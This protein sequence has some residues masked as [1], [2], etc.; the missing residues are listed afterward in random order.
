[1][2]ALGVIPNTDFMMFAVSSSQ[3]GLELFVKSSNSSTPTLL[4]DIDGTCEDSLVQSVLDITEVFFAH[5]S[6]YF[7]V[8]D[9]Q[10]WVT[11]GTNEST[12][13]VTTTGTWN[14]F[15][16]YIHPYHHLIYAQVRLLSND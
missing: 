1:M 8:R 4:R 6:M 9:N 13:L 14:Y 11:R 15:L 2:E 10:L 7:V 12:T 5:D 3:Y 16:F